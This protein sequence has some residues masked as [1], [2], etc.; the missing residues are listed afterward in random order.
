[1]QPP[2]VNP[3]QE[4]SMQQNVLIGGQTPKILKRT[5][6]VVVLQ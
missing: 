6:S 2:V 1:M 3:A 4:N 5:P